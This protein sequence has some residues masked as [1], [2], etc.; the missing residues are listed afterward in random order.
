MADSCVLGEWGVGE[1]NAVGRRQLEAG[2][3]QRKE[4][5]MSKESGD[6]WQLRRGW[7]WGPKSFRE[8]LLEQTGAKKGT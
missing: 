1:D 7:C 5:E 2:M 3:E 8:N 4:Q 6:W